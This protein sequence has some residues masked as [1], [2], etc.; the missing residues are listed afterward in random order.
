MAFSVHTF[1]VFI[2]LSISGVSWVHLLSFVLGFRGGRR[3]CFGFSFGSVVFRISV[4]SVAVRLVLCLLFVVAL[5][6]M[7]FVR[8]PSSSPPPRAGHRQRANDIARQPLILQ[9]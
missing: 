8:F 9:R 3:S 5:A 1:V 7:C 2:G 6:S 4:F